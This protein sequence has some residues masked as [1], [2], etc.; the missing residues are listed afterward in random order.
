MSHDDLSLVAA[1]CEHVSLRQYVLLDRDRSIRLRAT[2]W[3]TGGIGMVGRRKLS[4]IRG[5]IKDDAD[6]F[7]NAYLSVNPKK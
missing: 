1:Y 3:S 7:L 4:E 6:K 2:T 5:D